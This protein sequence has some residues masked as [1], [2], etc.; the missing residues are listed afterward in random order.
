M[1]YILHPPLYNIVIS[2]CVQHKD[3]ISN[4]EM[5]KKKINLSCMY[6]GTPIGPPPRKKILQERM[7]SS[8]CSSISF[9]S[10]VVQYCGLSSV[11]EC[12]TAIWSRD[13]GQRISWYDSCQLKIIRMSNIK[14]ICCNPRLHDLVLAVWPPC[15]A[16]SSSSSG[17]RARD[18]CH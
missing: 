18:P 13:I 17:A 11:E 6:L 14:D 9:L 1:Y 2:F 7:T 16:T 4:R 12:W 10:S 15:N 3:C 8:P 5:D